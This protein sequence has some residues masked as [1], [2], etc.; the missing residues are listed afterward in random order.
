M[1]RR[2]QTTTEEEKTPA[3][4]P[5]PPEPPAEAAGSAEAPAAAAP[6]IPAPTST[7]APAD[8]E[9]PAEVS[10]AHLTAMHRRIL[11]LQADQVAT[12]ERLAA[13]EK[14]LKASH[15]WITAAL[16]QLGPAIANLAATLSDHGDVIED[17]LR[18]I[19]IVAANQ[20]PTTRGE[21]KLP[22]AAAGSARGAPTLE[23]GSTGAPL[24]PGET[25]A[26]DLLVDPQQLGTQ[27]HTLPGGQE[28]EINV[29]RP[30]GDRGILRDGR[31]TGGGGIRRG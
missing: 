7:P 30:P 13:H 11:S 6:V 28:V 21:R 8:P 4:R 9:A 16:D 31:R 25:R 23:A 5:V 20:A 29:R 22:S 12:D 27:V 24:A 19:G 18:R 10:L 17:V 2:S 1:S 3:D 14:Q 26:T 15:D